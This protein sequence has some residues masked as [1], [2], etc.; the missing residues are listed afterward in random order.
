MLRAVRAHRLFLIALL[1]SCH[2]SATV[3]KTTPVASL[4]MYRT[5]ALRVKSTA[6]AAQGSASF[7]EN[8]LLQKLQQT[9]SFEQVV[10]GGQGD[11]VLDLNITNVG[12]GSSGFVTNSSQAKIDALLVLTDG[13]SGELLGTAR[14]HGKS[15]GVIINN[16]QPETE[17]ADVMAKTIAEMLAKSGCSGPRIAKVEPPPPPPP[18]AGGSGSNAEPPPVDEAKRAEA[19]AL[20]DQGKDKLRSADVEGALAAFVQAVRLLPDARYQFNVCLTYEAAEKWSD[21]VSACK[22]ARSMNPQPKLITKIDER[23]ELLS[24]HR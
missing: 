14:I 11:V 24:H 16:S 23:L 12:R 1:A 20:N 13:Q 3:E 19:E 4:Q 18:P 15:S 5:V 9:C 17:A 10:R 2:P 8:A 21:A 22:Q 6:F 7:L